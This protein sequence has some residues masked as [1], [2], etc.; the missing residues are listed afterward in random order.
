MGEDYKPNYVF[1]KRNIS[2]FVTQLFT[3]RNEQHPLLECL[4][5][6][7]FGTM[8]KD[9][10]QELQDFLEITFD[11]VIEDHKPIASF[12]GVNIIFFDFTNTPHGKVITQ[13]CK[14]NVIV[15]RK[16]PNCALLRDSSNVRAYGWIIP[17]IKGELPLLEHAYC[18]KCCMWFPKKKIKAHVADCVI[19]PCGFRGSLTNGKHEGCSKPHWRAS[20]CF[21][22]KKLAKIYLQ[23]VNKEWNTKDCHFADFEAFPDKSNKAKYTVYGGVIVK[24]SCKEKECWTTIGPNSMH[25]F[26]EEIMKLQGC[27]FFFYGGRF[28]ALLLLK[29]LI[30]HSYPILETSILQTG[31]TIL[32]YTIKTDA[33]E[34]QIKDLWRF[35][36]GTL[37]SNCTSWGV[38]EDVSKG[39][40]D[41]LKIKGWEDVET[42]K[43][44]IL[45]YMSLDGICMKKMYDL[46][47]QTYFK[48]YKIDVKEYMTASH[49][50]YG[51]LSSSWP[52]E[53]HE[54]M[55]RT[56]IKYAETIRNFYRGGRIICGRPRWES[57]EACERWLSEGIVSREEY[58]AIK[59]YIIYCDANSLYPSVMKGKKYPAGNFHHITLTSG[60]VWMQE[61]HL[62]G[63][64]EMDTWTRAAYRVVVDC[65]TNLNVAFLMERSEKQEVI[66][67]LYQKE[68]WWTGPELK[69]AVRLGYEILLIHEVL[70]W[71]YT[72]DL[73]SDFITK[74]YD[75]KKAAPKDTPVY[76]SAKSVMNDS[77]G[78]PAQKPFFE[79]SYLRKVEEINGLDPKNKRVIEKTEICDEDGTLLA[80][81]EKHEAGRAYTDFPTQFTSFI[82]G[83]SK[84]WMSLALEALGG[85]HD[86]EKAPFYGD[87]DSLFVHV[88]Q[89]NAMSEEWKPTELR[90]LGRFKLEINGKIIAIY[91]LAPKCYLFI[92]I[93]AKT[94]RIMCRTRC[95]GFPHEPNDYEA[96]EKIP[97]LNQERCEQLYKDLSKKNPPEYY[98]YIDI[99]ERIYI[100]VDLENEEHHYLARIPADYWVRVLDGTMSLQC[101]FGSMLRSNKPYDIDEICIQPNYRNRT[102]GQG[103]DPTK[104]WW[105]NGK[106]I[107]RPNSQPFET[108]Y[109]PGHV[110][111]EVQ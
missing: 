27:L 28:D 103:R 106:R 9:E 42:Y 32:T 4:S 69:E 50:A 93:C 83:Y 108:A 81:L 54:L 5:Q 15:D 45:E 40:F 25:D 39:E 100:F 65:P 91:V 70:V 18:V 57:M 62:K 22:E 73:Y 71:D 109:P 101:I 96:F 84:V 51:C 92:Y 14:D 87:T 75:M 1:F 90:E 85:Y 58:N 76:N 67:T 80:I 59:D 77:S 10:I 89:W 88:D 72:I 53:F 16:K 41:H 23:S 17:N 68:G 3:P 38:N 78:K 20:S 35:M 44:E 74:A 30:K 36:G 94:L 31:S 24:D 86:P 107:I 111:L 19:C 2:K 43:E 48:M 46:Y 95:K 63:I 37:K 56:P 66:Q 33:G 6:A 29:Y 12:F 82:L 61:Q 13:T 8:N 47:A 98:D 97:A 11:S 64:T 79:T 49:V 60:N 55:V 26:M 105:T 34:L 99:K 21:G 102:L 7:V 104:N 110:L 52:K